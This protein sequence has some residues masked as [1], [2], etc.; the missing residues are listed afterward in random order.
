MRHP[1]L[2]FLSGGLL[3]L[4]TLQACNDPAEIGID[5]VA[6]QQDDIITVDTFTVVSKV[7]PSDSLIA[8]RFNTDPLR[9]IEASV[10]HVGEYT[11]PAFGYVKSDMYWQFIPERL[12][13]DFTN[14]TY[15]S[16][17]L[18]IEYDS[19]SHYGDLTQ[20]LNLEVFRVIEP[21][22]ENQTIYID[23]SFDANPAP[24]GTKTFVPTPRDT[25][26]IYEPNAA[27]NGV[28]TIPANPSIRVRLDDFL[29]MNFLTDTMRYESDTAFT[30]SFRGIKLSS[31]GGNNL[32]GFLPEGIFTQL[33]L[34][35]TQDDTVRRRF[36]YRIVPLSVR[37]NSVLIDNTGSEAES[38]L[39]NDP[40]EGDSIL[41]I[42]GYS[43][44]IVELDIPGITSL[45][46]AI[47]NYA[48]LVIPIS[49]D[50][51]NPMD[52][53]PPLEQVVLSS[54][55][56][57]NNLLLI[58]DVIWATNRGDLGF[59]GGSPEMGSSGLEY[60]LRITDQAQSMA[61]GRLG[62]TL[63]LTA[64]NR[65]ENPRRSTLYGGNHQS[66]PIKLRVT[67]TRP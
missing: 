43:G 14:V 25:L 37:M 26:E 4:L 20:V 58:N 15:D 54:R 39:N 17:V 67:Y 34:Y 27:G 50:F 28:D 65:R 3:L 44:P 51:N 63:V 46:D 66:N 35:Y 59:F 9:R 60:R 41:F 1:F 55:G 48:E 47:I 56:N 21:M 16:L 57:D 42:Q 24:I 52:D 7:V 10:T 29:G 18:S 38:A 64:F 31:N 19:V 12:S 2:G 8:Y 61:L 30:D 22:N 32:V 36:D 5:I 13:P 6:G 53:F 33:S 62:T 23:E 49:S 45:N 40:T 11:D